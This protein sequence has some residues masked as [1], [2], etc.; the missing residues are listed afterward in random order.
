MA[1]DR[2]T[3]PLVTAT[4]LEEGSMRLTKGPSDVA[5][6]GLA[7]GVGRALTARNWRVATAESCTAG[8][9]AKA[10]T[11]VPGSSRW[12]EGGYIVYSNAAKVRA[13]KVSTTVLRGDGAV[14]EATVLAMAKGAARAT[15]ADIAIAISGIAGPDGGTKD[16]PVG[17]VWFGVAERQGLKAAATS[18]QF[19]GDRE[20]IRRQAVAVSLRLLLRR[21][22]QT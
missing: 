4:K 17:L 11:D 14:S 15:G 5:L 13:L 20:A 18:K 22:T 16:K 21:A 6:L 12:V 9:V 3:V 8:W 1:D 7:R 2:Q 19:R 10:L